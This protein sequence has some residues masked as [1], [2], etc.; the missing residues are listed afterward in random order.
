MTTLDDLELPTADWTPHTSDATSRTW[1]GPTG[2]AIRLLQIP[3]PSPIP[4]DLARARAQYVAESATMGGALIDLQ[5]VRTGVGPVLRSVFKYRSPQ[6]PRAIYYVG[7][8]LIPRHDVHFRL[9]TEAV[10]HGITGAREAAVLVMHPELWPQVEPTR[11][12]PPGDPPLRVI[13]SDEPRFDAVFPDHP[14]SRVRAQQRE[15]LPALRRRGA[16]N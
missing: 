12:V 9:H 6:N 14:L 8:L 15:I 10:E 5:R 1:W 3:G 2:V 11:D 16:S 7:I 13:P 4:L